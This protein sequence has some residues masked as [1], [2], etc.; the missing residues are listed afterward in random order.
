ML[1]CV[2]VIYFHITRVRGSG[3]FLYTVKS[4]MFLYCRQ[5]VATDTETHLEEGE[6][7]LVAESP[8]TTRQD[9]LMAS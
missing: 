1:L 8:C 9:S 6:V 7:V 2:R 3:L 5:M 4:C